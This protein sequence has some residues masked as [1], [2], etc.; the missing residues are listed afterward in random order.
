MKMIVDEKAILAA[1]IFPAEGPSGTAM[2][3]A[4]IEVVDGR[5]ANMSEKFTTQREALD[6]LRDRMSPSESRP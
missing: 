1:Q 6:C 5:G 3:R 4:M 2:Y